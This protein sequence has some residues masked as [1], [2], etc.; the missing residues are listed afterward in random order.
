[1]ELIEGKNR[2]GS[3]NDGGDWTS[4]VAMD[5]RADWKFLAR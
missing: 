4:D 5:S 3:Q 1:L 2:A